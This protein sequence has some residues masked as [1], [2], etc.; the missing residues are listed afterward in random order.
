MTRLACTQLVVVGEVWCSDVRSVRNSMK[1]KV[2]NHRPREQVLLLMNW[3]FNNRIDQSS[4]SSGRAT[5]PP[6]SRGYLFQTRFLPKSCHCRLFIVAKLLSDSGRPC[7][8]GTFNLF[9]HQTRA[10]TLAANPPESNV[11]PITVRFPGGIWAVC[12][13]GRTPNPTVSAKVVYL[14]QQG[15]CQVYR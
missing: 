9:H 10:L 14:H 3:I 6:P 8:Q 11:E 13:V 4:Q 5:N 15:A 12:F 1:A 7:K 2:T